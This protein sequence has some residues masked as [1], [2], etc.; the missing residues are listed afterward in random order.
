VCGEQD[1]RAAGALKGAAVARDR[2]ASMGWRAAAVGLVAVLAAGCTCQGNFKQPALLLDIEFAPGVDRAAVKL[3]SFRVQKDSA[4]LFPAHTLPEA[5]QQGRALAAKET[6]LVLLPADTEGAPIDVFVFAFDGAGVVTA[7]GTGRGV[8]VLTEERQVSIMLQGYAPPPP[9]PEDGGLVDAGSAC[10]ACGSQASC[11]LQVQNSVVCSKR[12]VA[13]CGVP[14]QPC[15][16]CDPVRADTCTAAGRCRCGDGPTCPQG[17][18]CEGGECVCN[19]AGCT[20]GCCAPNPVDGGERCLKTTN[21]YNASGGACGS[22]GARCEA[23]TAAQCSPQGVCTNLCAP[24]ATQCCQDTIPVPG[25]VFPLCG[26]GGPCSKCDPE[27]AN[28]CGAG[29]CKCFTLPQCASGTR[30][31][32]GA[33]GPTG[34]IGACTPVNLTD[35]G[36]PPPLPDGGA[37]CGPLCLGCCSGGVCRVGHTATFCGVGGAACTTCPAPA[38]CTTG[39]CTMPKCGSECVGCCSGDTCVPLSGQSAATCGRGGSMCQACQPGPL[40][41]SCVVGVCL[42]MGTGGGGGG[43]GAGGGGGGGVGLDAS[44]T[45]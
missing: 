19:A 28:R 8:P 40:G 26:L 23:C 16:T 9:P 35:A 5:S 1:L 45:P 20:D 18:A 3:L 4:D 36:T 6:A 29:A 10:S 27:R 21:G 30:C 31:T 17:L 42:N 14:G 24:T 22:K 12:D 15:G 7:A 32:A 43:G 2:E 44:V 13:N 11:C 37:A 25:D 33:M 38:S 39:V 34:A 41:L